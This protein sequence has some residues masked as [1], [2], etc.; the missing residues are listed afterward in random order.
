MY[1][2]SLLCTGGAY[3]L[4]RRAPR[5]A[6]R[7]CIHATTPPRHRAIAPPRHRAAVPPRHRAAAPPR[8]R[9]AAPPRHHAAAPPHR[10]VPGGGQAAT[11]SDGGKY[12]V[13]VHICTRHTVLVCRWKNVFVLLFAGF[14]CCILV[15]YGPDPRACT[16][17]RL[18][19]IIYI[20]CTPHGEYSH[21]RVGNVPSGPKVRPS[22]Q[23]TTL[24][25]PFL[26][27]KEYKLAH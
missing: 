21:K 16:S 20:A 9:A 18:Y 12:R 17:Y 22:P 15:V 3:L 6:A 27:R 23:R 4:C 26:D 13:R 11:H 10:L 7:A 14:V 25:T 2:T 8:H 19:F 24:K 1:S 5:R